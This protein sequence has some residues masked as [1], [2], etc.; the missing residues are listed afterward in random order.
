MKGIAII[1]AAG[2]SE[3]AGVDKIWMKINGTTVLEKATAPFFAC[4][5]IEEVILVVA[6]E[7]S[8]QAERLFRESPL[9]CH[10]V[11]GGKS[12]TESVFAALRKAKDLAGG[13]DAVVAVHDGAR[14][15]VS[16]EL[17]EECMSVAAKQGSAVP[18]IPCV[19]SLRKLT[20]DGSLPIP[21]EEVVRVQTPQCFRLAPLLEAYSHGESGSDDASLYQK[22]IAPVT[23]VKGDEN[24]RKITYLSDIYE[25]ISSR[26]GVGY[27]VHPLVPGRPLILGGVTVPHNKGLMG[28]S[29]AD[30]L[31]HAIM[32]ALLTAAGL[33]DIG[34]LFP[35]DDPAYEGADSLLLLR[36]VASRVQEAGFRVH[37]ISATILAEKPKLAPFLKKM[38]ARIAEAVGIPERAV[39][40][41]AT[42]TEKLGIIGEEKGI[43][44]HAVALLCEKKN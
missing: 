39:N 44:A 6:A 43:A 3:R 26:V 27:D 20:V 24:N 8:A 42:T 4:P 35:P 1:A 28:H 19:D 2:K 9:P 18:V 36:D 14:P 37:N 31:T 21:R 22:F 40:F 16:R 33:P 17:I 29:D 30:A 38:E 12:R 10:V 7:H 25:D 23:L 11:I 15:F 41:A 32:D 5:A 34:N 13:K